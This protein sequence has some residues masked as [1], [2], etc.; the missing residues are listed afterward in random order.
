MSVTLKN[1]NILQ[2]AV[3]PGAAIYTCPSGTAA[4]VL[5][6]T[7]TNDTT[8]VATCTFHKVASGGA[9]GDDNFILNAKSIS[10]QATY[11]CPEVVGQVLDAG[12]AIHAFG[13]VAT[14]LTVVIDVVEIV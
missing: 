14:Q 12:D 13:S 1:A 9:L 5:K 8:T 11:E 4:R 3:S 6:C 7:V 10:S 2:L